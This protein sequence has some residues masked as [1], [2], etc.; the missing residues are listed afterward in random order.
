[1]KIRKLVDMKKV[2]LLAVVFLFL[3][4]KGISQAPT[5]SDGKVGTAVNKAGN[6]TTQVAVSGAS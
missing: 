3:T 1:M 5:S 2:K 6:K 4:I